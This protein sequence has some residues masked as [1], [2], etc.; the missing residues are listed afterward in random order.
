M[1][2][3]AFITGTQTLKS[4][5][6]DI[7]VSIYCDADGKEWVVTPISIDSCSLPLNYFTPLIVDPGDRLTFVEEKD[8][9]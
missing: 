1:I 3:A 9:Y 7:S 5:R 6:E 4:E 2:V 8:E